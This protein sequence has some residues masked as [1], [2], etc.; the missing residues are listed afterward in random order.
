M[1]IL[2]LGSN[3]MLG[4][5]VEK[6]LI[7]KNVDIITTNLRWPSREFKNLVKSF[8]GQY[9]INCIGAI[10]QR[11]KDFEINWELPIY[12]DFYSNCNVIHPG[13]DCEMDSDN[14]GM[15]KKIARDYIINHGN[16]IKSIKTSIVGP[17]L[18]TKYSLMEWFLSQENNIT[19]KGFSKFYW[20][21]NTTLTWAK[22]CFELMMN[23]DSFE[24]ETIIS[25]DCI[26]KYQML[27]YFAEVF[28]KDIQILEVNVPKIYKCLEGSIKT[29]NLKEQLLEIKEFMKS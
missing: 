27:K 16:R 11:T 28:E 7:T 20:N 17:E 24:K 1:K 13:T 29:P 23:W 26:S 9:I 25:S 2:L 3:G 14:Y 18:N 12:L 21:G 10:H 5:M 15:S 19:I 4:H 8:N 6:Y 22:V